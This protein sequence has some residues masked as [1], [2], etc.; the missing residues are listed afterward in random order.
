M[1]ELIILEAPGSLTAL[2]Q[3]YLDT[4]GTQMQPPPSVENFLAEAGIAN[5]TEVRWEERRGR[6]GGW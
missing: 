5:A 6:E 1:N 3:F 2:V 4:S